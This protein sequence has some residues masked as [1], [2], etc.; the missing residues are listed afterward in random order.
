MNALVA[1]V[2]RLHAHNLYAEVSLMWA[3]PGNQ[4]AIDH[5][6]ILDQDHSPAAW[7]AIAN[8]FKADPERHLRPAVRAARHQLGVLE[9]RRRLLLGRLR[10]TRHAGRAGRDPRHRRDQRRHRL[11]HRLGEQPQQWLTNRPGR[12][13][14]PA[15]GRAARLRRRIPAARRAA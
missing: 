9:E 11:G 5:P 8:T 13:A 10:G 12:S 1:F 14:R 7:P 15:D 6:P 4:Q 2:N 3:A